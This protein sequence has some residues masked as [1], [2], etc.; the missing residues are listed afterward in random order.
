MLN[1]CVK[2]CCLCTWQTLLLV[3][4]VILLS[5]KSC[6]REN[7]EIK[8]QKII[9]IFIFCKGSSNRKKINLRM[10]MKMM[11]LGAMP[12]SS[13]SPSDIIPPSPPTQQPSKSSSQPQKPNQ[14]S[15]RGRGTQRK[16][17][18]ISSRGHRGRQTVSTSAISSCGDSQI[19]RQ[20]SPEPSPST[21]G[22]SRCHMGPQRQV[23]TVWKWID[24][25]SGGNYAP[26]DIPFWRQSGLRCNLQDDAKLID[27][28]NLYFTDAVIQKS[29]MKQTGMPISFWKQKVQ[30]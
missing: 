23:Q 13:P 29:L 30:I 6:D 5:D 8:S 25:T 2:K 28:F 19:D 20:D 12:A 14:V 18:L 16:T 3:Q 27:F 4:T 9:A 22:A 21:S 7:V 26:I 1:L 24:M 11:I 17:S 10:T 15:S